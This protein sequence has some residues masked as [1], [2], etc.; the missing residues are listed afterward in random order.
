MSVPLTGNRAIPLSEPR[1]WPSPHLMGPRGELPSSQAV[2]VPNDLRRGCIQG[3]H[4]ER[5]GQGSGRGHRQGRGD[6]IHGHLHE[7]D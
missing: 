7:E 1:G 6:V 3:N 4:H 2:G 5:G